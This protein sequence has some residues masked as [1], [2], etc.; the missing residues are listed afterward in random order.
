MMVRTSQLLAIK[1]LSLCVLASSRGFVDF[2]ATFD[3]ST[4]EQVQL[5]KLDKAFN[6]GNSQ[7]KNG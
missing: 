7:P 3:L 1:V 2:T 6:N 5:C 4:P